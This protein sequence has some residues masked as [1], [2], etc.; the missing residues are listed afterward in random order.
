[1]RFSSFC[2]HVNSSTWLKM[3]VSR[4]PNA[5]RSTISDSSNP[6]NSRIE[7]NLGSIESADQTVSHA[8]ALR[9]ATVAQTIVEQ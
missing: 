8:V 1:M 3:F 9:S 4:K 6:T 2:D 7:G 5:Q